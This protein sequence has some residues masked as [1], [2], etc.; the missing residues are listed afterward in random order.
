MVLVII[1]IEM[2]V[3]AL[4]I[5]F[6]SIIELVGALMGASS[7]FGAHNGYG[8]GQKNRRLVLLA[9]VTVLETGATI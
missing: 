2:L 6:M 7:G 5:V 3:I 1:V 8:I 9:M 4:I